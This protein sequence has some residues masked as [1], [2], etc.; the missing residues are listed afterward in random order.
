MQQ[1]ELKPKPDILNACPWARPHRD[2]LA[3]GVVLAVPLRLPYGLAPWLRAQGWRSKAVAA[4]RGQYAVLLAG[5]CAVE[6]LSWVPRPES[7]G[8]LTAGN[9]LPW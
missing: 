2:G 5:G 1:L 7:H 4:D 6:L 3:C 8:S 9:Y